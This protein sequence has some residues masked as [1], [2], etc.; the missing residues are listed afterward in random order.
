M[1]VERLQTFEEKLLKEGPDS[2]LELVTDE[3]LETLINA[4]LILGKHDQ[5][6]HMRQ[7]TLGPELGNVAREAVAKLRRYAK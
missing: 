6:V 7:G 2:F 3:I 1:S 4:A 5:L